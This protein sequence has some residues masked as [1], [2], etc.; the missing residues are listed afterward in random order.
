MRGMG[1]LSLLLR[2]LKERSVGLGEFRGWSP[3]F[4]GRSNVAVET[5]THKTGPWGAFIALAHE[6]A[7][8]DSLF[9][10]ALTDVCRAVVRT[11]GAPDTWASVVHW[12]DQPDEC[13]VAKHAEM[14][15]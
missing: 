8:Q 14:D 12:I 13:A 9:K 2:S 15:A 1:I 4:L 3:F 5:A 7:A 11:D 10:A 6:S